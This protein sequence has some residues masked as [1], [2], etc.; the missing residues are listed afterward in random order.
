MEPTRLAVQAAALRDDPD[1]AGVLGWS[2]PFSDGFPESP[3]EPM[4]GHLPGA[5]TV[6]RS[7]LEEVG[8]FD[9][10]LVA[11]EF[12]DWHLR[13]R[14]LGL[15]IDMLDVPVIRR[16]S[17]DANL[18]RDAGVLAAGYL[19][20]ARLAIERRRNQGSGSGTP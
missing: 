17:H 16:R 14:A 7:A 9:P 4:P 5:L 2:T 6:R 1:L 3:G 8:P 11:G 13:A 18:T 20:V 12:G 19:Q 15:R 10:T